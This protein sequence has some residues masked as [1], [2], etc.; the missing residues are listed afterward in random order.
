MANDPGLLKAF[1]Q[2]FDLCNK[3]MKY[4]PRR[5]RE[6]ISSVKACKSVFD[7]AIFG[8]DQRC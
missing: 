3:E 8:E 5:Y 1:S 2:M 7:S 6:V 4:L